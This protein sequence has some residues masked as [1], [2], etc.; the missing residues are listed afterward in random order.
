[1]GPASRQRI[2]VVRLDPVAHVATL[3]RQGQ[4]AGPTAN[5]KKQFHI[6]RASKS[7]LVDIVPGPARWKG[8]TTWVF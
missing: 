8:Y 6:T 2:T 3:M 4:G 5:E 7:Y 1:M